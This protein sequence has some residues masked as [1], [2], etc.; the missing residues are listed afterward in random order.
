MFYSREN[1]ITDNVIIWFSTWGPLVVS[2]QVA[3]GTHN[4]LNKLK[5]ITI[6]SIFSL[7]FDF[8]VRKG[9]QI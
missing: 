4:K 5:T 1:V 2:E 8:G 9:V 3:G 6:W 7:E